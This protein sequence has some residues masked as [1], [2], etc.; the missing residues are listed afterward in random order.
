MKYSI[1]MLLIIIESIALGCVIAVCVIAGV[2]GFKKTG[3]NGTYEP[4]K[5]V[6][7]MEEVIA[8]EN[9]V[10]KP[11]D[12][13]NAG[14]T[15]S[16][17]NSASDES[18]DNESDNGDADENDSTKPVK[19]S[20]AEI[21]AKLK[22]LSLEEKLYQLIIVRPETLMSL[23]SCTV[24]GPKTTKA[25]N[26][27]PVGGLIYTKSTYED[28][29]QVSDLIKATDSLYTD[30]IKL[31]PIIMVNEPGGSKTALFANSKTRH[32]DITSAISKG[33]WKD[34][35]YPSKLD[36]LV[37]SPDVAELIDEEDAEPLVS[38]IASHFKNGAD[39]IYTSANFEAVSNAL[40]QAVKTQA[41][42][43]ERVNKSVKKIIT[44]K[45]N[46]R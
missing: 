13:E 31:I 10:S 38:G 39:M 30:R 35:Q 25:I 45:M 29:K 16:T 9:L 20:E 6:N 36:D 5:N 33:G 2:F 21:D 14:N 3:D 4:S 43:E 46:E 22:S 40:K 8:G 26:D 34:G 18:K 11:D 28:E 37:I 17:T 24:A 15:V 12:N 7:S 23:N 42:T 44:I 1:N 41:I 27:S 32:E 19:V